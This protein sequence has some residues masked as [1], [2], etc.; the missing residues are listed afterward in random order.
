MDNIIVG[1]YSPE[2]GL[3]RPDGTIEQVWLGWIES[4]RRDW[5][6]FI[7]ADGVPVFYLNRD[8]ETGAIIE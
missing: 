7:R 6:A 4:A 2:D 8:P 1:R 5:I 3:V